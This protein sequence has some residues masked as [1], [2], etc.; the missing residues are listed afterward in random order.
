MNTPA[1]D[2]ELPEL[3][4]NSLLFVLFSDLRSRWA[5]T[6]KTMLSAPCWLTRGATQCPTSHPRRRRNSRRTSLTHSTATLRTN[7]STSHATPRSWQSTKLARCA[8]RRNR[9]KT[10]STSG[11]MTSRTMSRRRL[12]SRSR[13]STTIATTTGS[14]GMARKYALSIKVRSTRTDSGLVD[15]CGRFVPLLS[16]CEGESWISAAIVV[17][18][19]VYTHR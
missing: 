19:S 7:S 10:R 12:R 1:N 2:S 8:S 14:G 16:Q 11:R 13:I 17:G 9:T 15:C 3:L 6:N 18:L 4:L 5:L